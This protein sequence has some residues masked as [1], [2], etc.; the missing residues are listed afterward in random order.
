MNGSRF[1][2]LARAVA[3]LLRASD[4]PRALWRGRW[5]AGGPCGPGQCGAGP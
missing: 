2:D 3:E 4:T 5:F 1:D